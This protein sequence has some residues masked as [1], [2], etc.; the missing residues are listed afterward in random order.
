MKVN[1]TDVDPDFVIVDPNSPTESVPTS[2]Q[3]KK[4]N[5][6]TY[7]KLKMNASP[8]KQPST[9]KASSRPLTRVSTSKMRNPSDV[10]IEY[11]SENALSF[12]FFS[13]R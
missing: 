6:I 1:D 5:H 13:D 8:T 9:A 7:N 11:D 10:N 4:Q 3:E 2:P 12:Q